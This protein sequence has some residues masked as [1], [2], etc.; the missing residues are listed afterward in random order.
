MCCKNNRRDKK[1]KQKT[2]I[3]ILGAIFTF[4]SL[5][6]ICG[7]YFLTNFTFA[8]IPNSNHNATFPKP[9]VNDIY[10]DSAEQVQNYIKE[11]FP[12][13]FPV[14]INYPSFCYYLYSLQNSKKTFL[15]QKCPKE[16]NICLSKRH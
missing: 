8:K 2:I 14:C 12:D 5:I 4:F 7:V 11:K 3:I 16:I 9:K 13:S 1:I 15:P 10:L 6:L